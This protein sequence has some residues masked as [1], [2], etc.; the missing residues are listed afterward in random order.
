[1]CVVKDMRL[2]IEI[3]ENITNVQI[4]ELGNYL[5]QMPIVEILAGLKFAKRRWEFQDSGVL[6]IG[7]KSIVRKEIHIVTPEQA[8]W[9]LA[10]WK[11][12]VANY[13]KKGYSYPTISRIKK[14]L[15]EILNNSS[16]TGS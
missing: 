12:M 14:G 3:T 11:L 7:R 1:M 4:Q 9:R 15:G 16:K 2:E 10:N 8:K 5:G 13:R 6:C